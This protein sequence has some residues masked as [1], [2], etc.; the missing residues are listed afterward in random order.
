[1]A[2]VTT[3]SILIT[4][5]L[6]IGTVA[7][8]AAAEVAGVFSQ[9]RTH[10][11]VVA[12]SGSA[13]NDDYFVLGVGASYYLLDGFDVGLNIES[14]S[15]GT[16]SMIKVTPSVQY[17]FYQVP[18]VHPYVGAFYRRAYIEDYKD[19]DSTGGRVGV[20]IAASGNIF[21]G[22]GG[23]YE[24]YLDC[25]KSVYRDCSATYPEVTLTFAF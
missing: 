19:L 1:M 9:G 20:Y 12:G 11:S 14:W 21:L 18:R 22:V 3:G 10:L 7:P 4:A 17:V 8:A 24:S 2:R 25:D 6:S 23:V 15:G 5:A 13:F 16:P